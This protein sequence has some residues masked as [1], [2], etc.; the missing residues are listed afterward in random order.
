MGEGKALVR[1][2]PRPSMLDYSPQMDLEL[3]H[4]KAK[5]TAHICPPFSFFK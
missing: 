3:G 1:Y 4:L 2:S 5:D